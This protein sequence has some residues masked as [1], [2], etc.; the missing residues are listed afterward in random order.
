V[1]SGRRTEQAVKGMERERPPSRTAQW[2]DDL[3]EEIAYVLKPLSAPRSN[4]MA[5][6]S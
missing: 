3:A 4:N 5:A 6:A 1:A 2:A